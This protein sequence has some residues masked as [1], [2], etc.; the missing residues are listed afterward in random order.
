MAPKRKT[1]EEKQN[2][3]Q[4]KFFC[5]TKNCSEHFTF[6]ISEF[7]LNKKNERKRKFKG[8]C[9]ACHKRIAL[10]EVQ[11]FMFEVFFGKAKLKVISNNYND[12]FE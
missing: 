5:E 4:Q 12:L 6:T 3:F 9:N 1:N 11:F 8:L 10:T 2:E 7:D